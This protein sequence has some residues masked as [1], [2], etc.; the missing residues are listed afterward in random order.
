MVGDAS[1]PDALPVVMGSD[2]HVGVV[3]RRF[4]P[5]QDRHHIARRM[6]ALARIIGQRLEIGTV[7]AGRLQPELF[8]LRGK[9]V[10][11]FHVPRRQI[12]AT[13]HGVIGE[14]V[15]P[16][17]QIFGG[18][19]GMRRPRHTLERQLRASGR[20]LPMSEGCGHK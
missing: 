11:P 14:D 19:L 13:L 16:S 6:L 7:V 12:L 9:V 4:G 5:A 15:E 8:E 10:R 18:D 1:Y 2:G 3:Q 17:H 20:R